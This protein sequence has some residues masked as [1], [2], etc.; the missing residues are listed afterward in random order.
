MIPSEVAYKE[1]EEEGGGGSGKGKE[2]GWEEGR[3]EGKVR[4]VGHSQIIDIWAKTNPI[5]LRSKA[6]P[7]TMR[8]RI[9]G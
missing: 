8:Q 5:E 4:K 3:K 7:V 1:R 2:S 6:Y 9:Y